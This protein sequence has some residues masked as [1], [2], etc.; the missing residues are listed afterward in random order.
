M[1]ARAVKFQPLKQEKV[2]ETYEV[3]SRLR[4]H[5]KP[6]TEREE[7]SEEEERLPARVHEER[8]HRST[9]KC[10][11]KASRANGIQIT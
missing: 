6:A 8:E 10:T 4:S 5:D 11:D 2:P 3:A 7:V 9:W 1:K